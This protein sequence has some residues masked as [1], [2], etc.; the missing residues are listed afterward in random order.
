VGACAADAR[1][2]EIRCQPHH[3][4]RDG[5]DQEEQAHVVG[6]AQK[7]VRSRS[8][9]HDRF[10]H[11]HQQCIDASAEQDHVAQAQAREQQVGTGTRMDAAEGVGHHRHRDTGRGESPRQDR[12]AC[13]QEPKEEGAVKRL[14]LEGVVEVKA[15]GEPEGE[16]DGQRPGACEMPHGL[17]HR[18]GQQDRKHQIAHH[19]ADKK[20]AR[21]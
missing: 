15:R 1:P 20:P 14:R 16:G 5:S 12:G 11:D 10:P 7:G 13:R 6:R 2:D 3:Q 4:Y 8:A 9:L 21:R 18:L 17:G 19:T